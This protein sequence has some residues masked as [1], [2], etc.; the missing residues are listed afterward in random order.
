L[1]TG[2]EKIHSQIG[3]SYP[4]SRTEI[5]KRDGI[6]KSVD[7]PR[8]LC[9]EKVSGIIAGDES[10]FAYLIESDAIFPSSPCPQWPDH[11][12]R[13][14]ELCLHFSTADG[15]LILDALPKVSKYNQNDFIGNLLPAFDQFRIGNA[16]DKVI[17]TLIVHLENSRC[18]DG[19]R[20]TEQMLLKGLA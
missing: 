18:H 3:A 9:G 10:R 20:I 13:A 16:R 8:K 1:E 15:R 17:P 11:Q 4:I 14:R 19:A 2:F 5:E 6:S 12:F 7:H